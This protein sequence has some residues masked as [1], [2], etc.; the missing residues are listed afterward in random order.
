MNRKK[1]CSV[2]AVFAVTLGLMATVWNVQGTM[3]VQGVSGQGKAKQTEEEVLENALKKL[4]QAE[5][6]QA[7]LTM[8]MEVEVFRFKLNAGAS[9]EMVTFRS[10][11]KMKSELELDMGLLGENEI[12]VYA[13]EQGKGYQL[14]IEDG[15]GWKQQEVASSR[16]LRYNGQQLMK[17][18]L[19]Q[20]VELKAAG[21]E[22]LASGE[23]YK[24]VGVVRGDG[25]STILLDTGLLEVTGELF[26][27]T[28]LKG[29]GTL[30]EQR[31]KIA[32]MMET[33]E[34]LE[35]VL[36]VDADTGY[37]VQ[38]T[39]DITKM[40]SDAYR[41]LINSSTGKSKSFLSK[42]EITETKIVIRCSNYNSAE[43]FSIPAEAL[44]R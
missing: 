40:L 32:A 35:V 37:P 6:M 33:A 16:L 11:L 21:R 26:Q 4:E 41:R 29:F 10:P 36:W 25:L 44:R 2:A 31:E 1:F 20:I 39:M 3:K 14:F 18:Y 19:E 30:L 24:Y 9:M 8:D 34:D 5:S 13:G 27:G 43:D 22:K 15:N 17:T 42:I 28:M 23:A 7:D 38:C 12:S